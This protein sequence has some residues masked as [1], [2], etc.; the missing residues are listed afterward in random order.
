MKRNS[1]G[2]ENQTLTFKP[3][4][5]TTLYKKQHRGLLEEGPSNR[6]RYIEKGEARYNYNYIY[7]SIV[8]YFS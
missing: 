6:S 1:F 3:P 2:P 7:L 8:F 4:L 5:T